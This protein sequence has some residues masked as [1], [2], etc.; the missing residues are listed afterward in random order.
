VVKPNITTPPLKSTVR[1]KNELRTNVTKQPIPYNDYRRIYCTIHSL[2]ESEEHDLG[3]SCIYFS[4]TGAV[5]LR[6]Q[7]QLEANVFMGLAAFKVCEGEQ[8]ILTFGES[9]ENQ[10][11]ST[12]CGF[13]SWVEIGEWFIDFTAPQFSKLLEYSNVNN[14]CP[15]KMFQKH[16]TEMAKHPNEIK[17]IGDF[18]YH[19]NKQL[20]G[21]MTDMFVANQKNIDFINVC[22]D[23]YRKPPKKMQKSI[24][25]GN[26]IGGTKTVG[27]KAFPISG[28]W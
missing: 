12:H 8:E 6:E 13:H 10:V 5:I 21:E 18:F 28:A 25:L 14:T 9:I 16:F 1:R 17:Y 20:A 2:L 26:G 11:Q 7:Y 27:L 23:W 22:N 24:L 3:R 4:L 19:P 15:S